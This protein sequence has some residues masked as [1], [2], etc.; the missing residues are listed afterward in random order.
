MLDKGLR[1]KIRS[2]FNAIVEEYDYLE[3]VVSE[4]EEDQE[5]GSKT[6]REMAKQDLEDTLFD[7]KDALVDLSL[8]F[9]N[10]GYIEHSS[11][12]NKSI[13]KNEIIDIKINFKQKTSDKGKLTGSSTFMLE[14][15]L[16]HPCLMFNHNLL[17][18]C[19]NMV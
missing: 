6:A 8:N 12:G 2:Y 15:M 9:N 11:F 14:Q 1:Q 5:S 7:M 3:N 13:H 19:Q 10:V 4:D 18:E 16:K 17:E